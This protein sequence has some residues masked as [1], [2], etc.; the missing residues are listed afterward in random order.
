MGFFKSAWNFLRSLPVAK[1]IKPFWQ[2]LAIELVQSEGDILQASVK[3]TLE[4][5]GPAGIDR[6]MDEWQARIQRGVRALPLPEGIESRICEIVLDEGDKLQ[7]SLKHAAA[8]G[9]PAAVDKAF[10]LAQAAI[11]GKL[12]AL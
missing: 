11:L 2:G 3:K 7:E 1:W 6:L 4:E 9:G 5:R 12:K 10:D 8:T